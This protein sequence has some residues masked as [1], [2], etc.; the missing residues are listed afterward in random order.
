MKIGHRATGPPRPAAEV[1][2]LARASRLARDVNTTGRRGAS[3]RSTPGGFM[4]L[5]ATLLCLF[6]ASSALAQGAAPSPSA[7]PPLVSPPPPAASAEPPPPAAAVAP[8]QPAAPAAP[9]AAPA[10]DN[11]RMRL[12]E[13]KL[14]NSKRYS[15]FS[16]GPGGP[17]LVFGSIITGLVAGGAFNAGI[18]ND[19]KD[20][21]AASV[22]GGVLL[23]GLATL[24]QY[25]AYTSVYG[26]MVD[27][28][29]AF[30]GFLFGF[31]LDLFAGV[32]PDKR[33][34]APALTSSGA[35]IASTLVHLNGDV[36]GDDAMLVTTGAVYATWFSALGTG[37]AA[38]LNA[39]TDG[40]V[41]LVAPLVGMALGAGLTQVMKVPAGRLFKLNLIPIGVGAILLTVGTITSDKATP[42]VWG[43]AMAGTAVSAVATGILTSDDP[44]PEGASAGFKPSSLTPS[45]AFVRTAQN[46][47]KPALALSG[48]F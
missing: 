42:L 37:M 30:S 13:P 10:P 31:G 3:P 8:V 6:F 23:G 35:L 47:L 44:A 2:R 14:G 17:L 7:P 19:S 48:A 12:Q 28:L 29:A 43:M 46:E 4:K 24:Y 26:S 27:S 36:D 11:G 16:R 9:A 1:H 15:R 33:W 32:D 5:A 21:F 40:R 38:S 39:D 45:M 34:L 25:Y 20:V 18:N 22:T 41:V